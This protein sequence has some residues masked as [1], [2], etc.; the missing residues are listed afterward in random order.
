ME[1]LKVTQKIQ[2][3]HDVLDLINK[4]GLDANFV[5]IYNEL[6]SDRCWIDFMPNTVYKYIEDVALGKFHQV[7]ISGDIYAYEMAQ[8]SVYRD[9]YNDETL[10]VYP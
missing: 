3:T 5:Y 9:S 8:G 2:H 10:G 6:K 7:G 1:L 4:K